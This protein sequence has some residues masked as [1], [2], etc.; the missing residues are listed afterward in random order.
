MRVL[1]SAGGW[2][3]A[4]GVEVAGLFVWGD[5]TLCLMEV[6]RAGWWSKALWVDVVGLGGW[7]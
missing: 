3:G 5:K 2:D 6:V 7:W 1:V 4:F